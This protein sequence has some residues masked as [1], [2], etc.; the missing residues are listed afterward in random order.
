MTGICASQ[1]SNTEVSTN[2]VAA[3]IRCCGLRNLRDVQ[4][5][6]CLHFAEQM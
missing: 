3:D 5:I 1:N 2:L 4:G 6:Q